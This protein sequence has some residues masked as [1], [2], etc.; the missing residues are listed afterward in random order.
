MPEGKLC[1]DPL[2]LGK[3]PELLQPGGFHLREALVG[4]VDERGAP[5]ES[6]RLREP[7][8]RE[9]RLA[10]FERL[11]PLRAQALEEGGVELLHVEAKRVA[12]RLVHEAFLAERPPQIRDVHLDHV[13]CGRGRGLAPELVDDLVDRDARSAVHEQERE[14]GARAAAAERDQLAAAPDLQR[15]EEAKF[16]RR[17]SDCNLGRRPSDFH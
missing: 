17:G 13:P 15:A 16:E 7:G 10:G 1:V 12:G 11:L 9:L 3:K 8:R 6:Q 14:Q 2:L 5:P 4:D